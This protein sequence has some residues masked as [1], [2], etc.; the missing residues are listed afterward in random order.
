MEPKFDPTQFKKI[1]EGGFVKKSAVEDK[2]KAEFMAYAE[3]T[4][5]DSRDIQKE[6]EESKEMIKESILREATEAAEVAEDNYDTLQERLRL[7]NLGKDEDVSSAATRL[8]AS[9]KEKDLARGDKV[10]VC[11]KDGSKHIG[12]HDDEGDGPENAVEW[13]KDGKK[14]VY[15]LGGR[16]NQGEFSFGIR[17]HER[18]PVQAIKSVSLI[19]KGSRKFAA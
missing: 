6:V 5:I 11:L 9:F 4:V 3:K 1:E 10:E 19:G 13:E 18:F 2:D 12:W 14:A 15:A 17:W 7:E 8:V 16:I